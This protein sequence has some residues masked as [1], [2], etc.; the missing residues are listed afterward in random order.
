MPASHEPLSLALDRRPGAA[1]LYRQVRD[2]VRALVL[3]GTLTAGMR[4]PPEREMATALSVNRTTV[5]RA[6]QEL[7]ADGLVEPRG[8]AGTVVRSPEEPGALAAQPPW[9]LTLPALGE[10]SLGPE[11][12]LLRDVAAAS[13]RPGMVSLAA[14]VPGLELLPVDDLRAC[15]DDALSRWGR[16]AMGY[17]EVE[18]FAPLREILAARMAGGRLVGPGDGVLVVAGATQGLAL[19]ARV[20]VEPGDEVVVEAPTYVGTLQTFAL[21]GARLIGVPVDGDGIRTDL[22]EGILARRRV[23]LVVVQPSYHNPTGALLS[24]ARRER[25]LALARR[26]AVPVLEDDPYHELGFGAGP[27]PLKLDDRAGSVIYLGTFSKSVCP[28]IRVGWMVAPR[29]VL[30]RLV[31]AKQFADLNTSAVGQ[32]MLAEFLDSGRHERHLKVC[33]AVYRERRDVLLRELATVAGHLE[34]PPAPPGG[35]FLWCR[36]RAGPQARLLA[37]LAAREGVAIVAGEAFVAASER[38]QTG[39]DRVRLSYAGCTPGQTAEGVHRLRAALE[40]LPAAATSA[41]S[42]TAVVV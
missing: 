9:L 28:G 12:M 30:A 13:G 4:L 26:F 5:T 24:A 33:R 21:A 32:L 23:R 36:L 2:G 6:Y 41:P 39:A 27:G 31:L 11:P 34:T 37:A 40:Q 25:L 10:G 35:F 19:A 16:S 38:G 7:V 3:A 42:G 14:G 1:P 8:S 22:L 15:L 18:G 17:G 20:L 29:P